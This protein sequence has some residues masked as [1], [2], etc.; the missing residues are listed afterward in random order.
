MG[1]PVIVPGVAGADETLTAKVCAVVLPQL[2]LAVTETLPL[3]EEGVAVIELVDELPVHPLGKV[4]VYE[5]APFTLAT[6]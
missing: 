5:V 4:Q 2:L 1:E 3:V 6:E